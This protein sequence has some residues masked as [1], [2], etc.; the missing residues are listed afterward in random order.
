M[1]SNAT[2]IGLGGQLLTFSSED[3][4]RAVRQ[5]VAAQ[6]QSYYW[7]GYSFSSPTTLVSSDGTATPAPSFVVD[8]VV[9]GQVS[10]NCLVILQNGDLEGR[11][12][13]QDI[14][15][16]CVLETTSKHTISNLTSLICSSCTHSLMIGSIPTISTD[17]PISSGDSVVIRCMFGSSPVDSVSFYRDGIL[18]QTKMEASPAMLTIS[19]FSARNNGNYE[20]RTTVGRQVAV[21][22][23][24]VVNVGK[25]PSRFKHARLLV[26]LLLHL[27]LVKVE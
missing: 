9:G 25:L 10:D 21:S 7:L 6:S 14:H 12:C 23:V 19:S 16:T 15:H 3:E 4:L 17:Y 24:L 11:D 26:Y 22:R 27:Y 13:S 2:C 5:Y 20:C 1:S 8:A 18:I